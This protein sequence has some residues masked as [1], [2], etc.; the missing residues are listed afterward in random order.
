M[1]ASFLV[2]HVAPPNPKPKAT[3]WDK[4]DIVYH[5]TIAEDKVKYSNNAASCLFR[6]LVQPGKPIA[7]QVN[8]LFQCINFFK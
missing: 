2:I 1:H 6:A 7:N 4:Q 5:F 3:V 8:M